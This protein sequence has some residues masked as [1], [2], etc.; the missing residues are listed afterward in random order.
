MC[1]VSKVRIKEIFGTSRGN[2]DNQSEQVKWVLELNADYLHNSKGKKKP[3]DIQSVSQFYTI[4]T[5]PG[6]LIV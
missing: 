6:W 2:F 5:N 3:A 4:D 1:V